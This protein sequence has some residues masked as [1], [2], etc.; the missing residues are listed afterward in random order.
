MDTPAMIAIA[1]FCF[2]FSLITLSSV[3]TYSPAKLN[4][5]VLESLSES[6]GQSHDEPDDTADYT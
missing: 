4:R 3:D 1:I 5:Q 6:A 2:R